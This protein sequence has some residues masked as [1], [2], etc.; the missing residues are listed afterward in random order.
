ME[1][2]LPAAWSIESGHHVLLPAFQ[3]PAATSRR[4]VKLPIRAPRVSLQLPIEQ[5]LLVAGIQGRLTTARPVRIRL[6]RGFQ[7]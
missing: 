6:A 2:I 3:A 4:C 5:N 1:A 7:P